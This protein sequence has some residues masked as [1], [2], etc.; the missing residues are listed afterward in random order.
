MWINICILIIVIFWWYWQKVKRTLI[1]TPY[2]LIYNHIER[3]CKKYLIVVYVCTKRMSEKKFAFCI[4]H[5]TVPTI[6]CQLIG[7]FCSCI[8]QQGIGFYSNV[9]Y[10]FL[11]RKQ[12][13]CSWWKGAFRKLQFNVMTN[14][15]RAHHK[16]CNNIFIQLEA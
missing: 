14:L 2:N 7:N 3:S 5:F 1:F 4:L 16:T 12:Q 8:V 10:T 11:Q 15:S 13:I 6:K 9:S